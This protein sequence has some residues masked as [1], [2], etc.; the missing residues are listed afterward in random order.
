MFQWPLI[1]SA[2]EW[3]DS[4]PGLFTQCI[5]GGGG[6]NRRLYCVVV[7]KPLLSLEI[8]DYEFPIHWVWS[9][10][11][12]S[13]SCLCWPCEQD[14]RTLG[15]R[16]PAGTRDVSYA[17]LAGSGANPASYA[18]GTQDDFLWGLVW[19]WPLTISNVEFKND[20]VMP[21]LPVRFCGVVCNEARVIFT[22][23]F[24][25]QSLQ[26]RQP[27]AS[28]NSIYLLVLV[29]EMRR[30]CCEVTNSVSILLRCN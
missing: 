22:F 12:S 5:W 1:D 23:D 20:V 18:P 2:D 15:V 10:Q 30:V 11:M 27:V 21:P 28:L 13:S 6:Q 19:G 17:L 25:I 29:M 9:I 24:C 16:F 8:T 26:Q 3:S 14:G 4:R 7:P